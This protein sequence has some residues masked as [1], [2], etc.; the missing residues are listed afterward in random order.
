MRHP[1]PCAAFGAALLVLA[2]LPAAAEKAVTI[3]SRP[4][5]TESIVLVDPPAKPVATVLLLAGGNGFIH[6]RRFPDR[7]NQNFLVRTRARFASNGFLVAILDV[8]S[9]HQESGLFRWR[10]SDEH[11][12]DIAAAVKWLRAHDPAPVWLVGTSRGSVSAAYAAAAIPVDGVVL[13]SSVTRPARRD[14]TNVMEARLG[15]IKAPVLIAS[16]KQDEC[17]VTPPEDA[18]RIKSALSAAPKVDIMLFEGGDS[19]RS[20][21]CEALAQHGYIGIENKVVDAISAWIK[22]QTKH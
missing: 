4:G 12:A 17:P 8:P 16:H 7:L 20:E 9:D 14:P 1:V 13:T 19:P 10:D 18:E 3:D 2:A 22:A 5:V 6:P 21:P 15:N 11:V